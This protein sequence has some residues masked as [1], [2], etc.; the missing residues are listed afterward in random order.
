MEKKNYLKPDFA[1]NNIK[2]TSFIAASV[3]SGEGGLTCSDP[4]SETVLEDL[5]WVNTNY[6]GNNDGPFSLDYFKE[7]L[8]RKGSVTIHAGLDYTDK[9]TIVEEGNYWNKKTYAKIGG[10]SFEKNANYT[11][12]LI[13]DCLHFEK[14]DG[15]W[16]YT[17]NVNY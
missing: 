3:E 11:V 16:N 2:T 10:L 14:C 5:F 6:H 9:V 13:D 17:V 1:L 4:I 12:T 7:Y 15:C 8:R